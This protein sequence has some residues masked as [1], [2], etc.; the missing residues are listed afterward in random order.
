MYIFI[1]MQY[2]EETWLNANQQYAQH[3]RVEA[4]HFALSTRIVAPGSVIVHPDLPELYASAL[5]AQ[6]TRA[7][8][9]V[10]A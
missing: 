9:E 4:A 10:R 3:S 2:Q 6:L 5:Y 7:S 1:K 8:M